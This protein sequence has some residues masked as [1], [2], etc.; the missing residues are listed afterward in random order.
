M[1]SFG[2]G[3]YEQSSDAS[4]WP[5]CNGGVFSRYSCS[6]NPGA[7]AALARCK[8][9]VLGTWQAQCVGRWEREEQKDV[10]ETD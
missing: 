4:V 10:E 3:S 6:A 8:Q 2:L 1:I 7:A 9:N 5:V